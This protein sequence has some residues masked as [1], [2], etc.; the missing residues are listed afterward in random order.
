MSHRSDAELLR[1][2]T[3]TD[4]FVE[5]YDRHS[6]A[7]LAYLRQKLPTEDVATEL[8]SE[9]FAQAW[10]HR[11]R[12][13]DRDYQTALPWL[14][15]IARNLQ[16]QFWRTSVNT[17]ARRK[18]EMPVSDH[19]DSA[20]IARLDATARSVGIHNALH[21]L[22]EP[23]REIVKL[24]VLDELEYSEIASRLNCTEQ[25]ARKRLSLALHLLRRELEVIPDVRT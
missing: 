20:F 2:A 4:A 14:I 12:F 7:I 15:G 10:L 18:L 8:L 19:D 22:S 9:T 17:R 11:R 6:A 3:R 5:I 25:T 24:R 21:R 13:R 23:S 16:R 1:D